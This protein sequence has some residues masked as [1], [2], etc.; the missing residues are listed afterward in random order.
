MNR[1]QGIWMIV[2]FLTIV[3]GFTFLRYIKPDYYESKAENRLLAEKPIKG[4]TGD[5]TYSE[6]Y[7][8]Y[9]TDQFPM[10]D[11]MLRLHMNTEIMMN[12]TDIKGYYLQDDKW[13]FEKS[14]LRLSDEAAKMCADRVNKYGEIITSRGK[15]FYYASTPQKE[16]ILVDRM[17]KYSNLHILLNNRERFLN[18][19]DPKVVS[20]IDLRSSFLSTLSSEE[21]DSIYFK[22]DNH[23]NGLGGYL[24]FKVIMEGIGVNINDSDYTFKKI[25]N[26]DFNGIY[27]QNLYNIYPENEDI[28]YVYRKNSEDREYFLHNGQGFQSVEPSTIIGT[29]INGKGVTYSTAYTSS[30]IHYKVI[31]KNPLIDKKLLIYR[32]SYHSAMSWLYE[33]IYREVEVVDPRYI[34]KSKTTSEEIAKTTDADIVLMMY[35]DFGF[36]TMLSEME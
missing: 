14:D 22:S 32:D 34:A 17:P 7:E 20:L 3:F 36:I 5:E 24:G 15:E 13:I 19:L 4:K 11:R 8:K 18:G 27:N 30:S 26:R 35:N 31:N 21:L 25:K 1:K 29:G 33:D 6:A 28:D 9:V 16:N 10:R 23:W 12:K 2:P